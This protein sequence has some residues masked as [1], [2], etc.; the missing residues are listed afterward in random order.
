MKY[1]LILT[2]VY[3]GKHMGQGSLVKSLVVMEKEIFQGKAG[4]NC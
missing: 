4:R 3:T 2:Y 1:N